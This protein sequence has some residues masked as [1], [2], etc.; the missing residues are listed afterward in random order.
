[1]VNRAIYT[2]GT[3]T[4][5]S[6]VNW[7]LLGL[8]IERPSYGYELAQRFDT[9][10]GDVLNVSSASHIYTALNALQARSLIEQIPSVR[11]LQP[12]AARQPKPHYRA[13][14][15]GVRSYRD[16]LVAQMREDRSRSQLLVRQLAALIREPEAALEVLD[17]YEQACLEEASRTPMYRSEE[18]TDASASGLVSRLTSEEH[19]LAA[20]ARLA[21]VQYARREFAVLARDRGTRP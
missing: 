19:R 10:Y 4:M 5:R 11:A 3:A 14:E 1:M 18:S 16:R 13:T 12:D 21:W 2:G 17:R 15:L 9:A 6:P 20:D 8:V 7:A